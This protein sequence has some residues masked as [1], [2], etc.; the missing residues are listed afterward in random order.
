M[1][2][3]VAFGDAGINA[4]TGTGHHAKTFE[5]ARGRR[6]IVIRILRIEADLD[7][8]AETARGI[9]FETLAPRNV[10]L[11]FHNI[12]TRGAFGDGMLNLQPGIHFHEKEL[13][14]LRCVE[15]FH[16]AGVGVAGTLA[17]ANRGFAQ[18]LIL[19]GR[20]RRGR[21]LFEDFLMPALNRA[22]AYADCPRGSEVVGDDLDLDV[23]GS[24]DQSLH[25]DGGVPECLEGLGAGALKRLRQLAGGMNE[26]NPV[27]TA[28]RSRFDQQRKA[29]ALRMGQS[30]RDG[31]DRT[32]TPGSHR[33][34][35]LFR[36]AFGSD[37]VTEAAHDIATWADKDDS[38]FLAEVSE[39]CVFR[40]EAPSD[41]DCI[42]VRF[43]QNLFE[44]L[45]VEVGTLGM[46]GVAIQGLGGTERERLVGFADE[47]GMAVGF[48]EKRDGA[49]RHAVLR[50][51]LTDSMDE[52]HR[53]FAA[54]HNRN[55]SKVIHHKDPGSSSCALLGRAHHAT[56]TASP[57]MISCSVFRCCSFTAFGSA[58]VW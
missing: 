34:L 8:V 52:A 4:H 25:K 49:Q 27:A 51:E 46:Q 22:I 23:A 18:I 40:Y 1:R 42:G 21:R 35:R 19:L 13:P 29:Q 6:E 3:A 16:R 24:L 56:R 47:H 14:G 37:L 57:D 2:N 33:D 28:A 50:A 26:T 39:G 7:C 55:P 45:V 12:D 11:E 38:H 41:P 10:D 30:I 36:E 9:A 5:N 32:A 54:V 58:T 43:R 31:F 44:A 48:G 20:K 17:E 15:K 53:G